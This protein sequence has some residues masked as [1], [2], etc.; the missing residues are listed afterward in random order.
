MDIKTPSLILMSACP[1]SGKSHMIK[2]LIHILAKANRFKY[3]KVFTGTSFTSFFKKFLPAK[4]VSAYNAN[5]LRAFLKMQKTKKETSGN[6]PPAF[7]I[8][9]DVLGCV[10][11]NDKL[12]LHV[13]TTYRHYNL[14]VILASQYLYA[15]PPFI[16]EASTYVF[17]WHQKTNRNLDAV[18]QSYGASD[19]EPKD[20]RKM[21]N[22]TTRERFVALLINNN[23]YET[24]RKYTKYKAPSTL[25]FK[26]TF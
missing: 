7:L 13:L 12:I 25:N 23:E 9:D 11:F 14:V 19:Y 8:F 17:V 26:I 21:I 16:R 22:D 24:S 20:F 2:H 5:S 10:K 3:G 18:Y 6:S 4:A 1:G 15:I